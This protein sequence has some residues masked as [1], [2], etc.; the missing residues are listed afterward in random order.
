[1]IKYIEHEVENWLINYV[2]KNE[3]IEDTLH[4]ISIDHREYEST[5][6]DIKV[7]QEITVTPMKDYIKNWLKKYLIKTIEEG[8]MEVVSIGHETTTNETTKGPLVFG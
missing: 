3:D 8:Q 5:S 4:Q 2:N 7:R 1:M 6:F